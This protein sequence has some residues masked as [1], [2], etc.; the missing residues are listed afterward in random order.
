MFLQARGSVWVSTTGVSEYSEN[1]ILLLLAQGKGVAEFFPIDTT[2]CP[3][4]GVRTQRDLA[5]PS[6]L[7]IKLLAEESSGI[8]NWF[9]QG[10]REWKE[11]GLQHPEEVNI[12]VKQ[13]QETEDY[14]GRCLKERF[15]ST[16]I[17]R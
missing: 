13:W 11:C 16:T 8:L 17:S 4:D 9:L 2:L 10:H 7:H 3:F 5:H 1:G 14:L 6:S 12:A 15:A